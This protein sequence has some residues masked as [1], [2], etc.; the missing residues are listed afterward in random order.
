MWKSLSITKKIW[1]SLSILIISY[2]ISMAVG[3]F[4]GKQ[5]EGRLYELSDYTFPAAMESQKVL[6]N[7]IDQVQLYKDSILMG[8]MEK[9]EAA[10]DKSKDV[11][12][13]LQRMV[14]LTQYDSL[15]NKEIKDMFNQYTEY[16]EFAKPVYT[17]F[18][19]AAEDATGIDIDQNS[20]IAENIKFL[21]DQTDSL[22][23]KMIS[24]TSTL[25]D[26]LKAELT[27]IRRGTMHQRNMNLV[28]FIIVVIGAFFFV[29]LIVSRSISKPL[30][31]TVNM[32]RD[33][34][35][36]EGDLTKRLEVKSGDEVG[37]LAKWFN[38]FVGNLHEMVRDI[39]DNA[40]ILSTSSEELSQLSSLMSSGAD[41]M[42]LKSNSVASAAEEM[43]HNMTSVAVTMEQ[44]ST[45]IN[46]IAGSTE[47]MTST[48]N[49][50]ASNSEEA[51]TIS[52]EAVD[53]SKVASD[54]L[55]K[56]S[57]AA[58]KIGKIT[59]V[60]TEISEQTNLLA[61]NATIEAAR[62]GDAG[63]GFGVVANEIKDLAKQ[64][65]ESTLLIKEQIDGIQE[66]TNDA[67]SEI[68]LITSVINRANDT[69]GSIASAIE[70]QTVTSKEIATNVSFA[71]QGILEVNKN[72]SQSSRV[73][74]EITK[75]VASG[76]QSAQEV[77]TNSSQVSL[78]SDELAELASRLNRLVGK[79]KIDIPQA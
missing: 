28:A 10:T 53:Q 36:G 2:F 62:A 71:S 64:T 7:F 37:E 3:F 72:V 48:I 8:E 14:K 32:L 19:N 21:G 39:F 67:S 4:L 16:T 78:R 66:A 68:N 9:L 59:E 58:N 11:K 63:K 41:E 77:S 26:D 52:N 75:D 51:R 34:A 65:A 35:E 43:S 61:L 74:E 17:E 47:E 18:M 27:D 76:N 20:E 22:E 55:N 40:K 25:S 46:M 70:Q 42:S 44:A 31:D 23:T 60:I 33:I 45:N 54:K 56:L 49:E 5:T 29:S 24:M 73:A 30:K 12:E 13:N 15:K 50:I 38:T 69:V 1:V 57:N 79:F 6:S